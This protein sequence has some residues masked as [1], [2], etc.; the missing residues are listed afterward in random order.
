MRKSLILLLALLGSLSAANGQHYSCPPRFQLNTDRMQCVALICSS[1]LNRYGHPVSCHCPAFFQ[2]SGQIGVCL[3]LVAHMSHQSATAFRCSRSINGHG[4]PRTC[5]C[6]SGSIYSSS[7]G[8]CND[9]QTNAMITDNDIPPSG[10]AI[11]APTPSHIQSP[12]SSIV[13]E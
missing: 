10:S 3:D 6:P 1:A 2:Y 7:Q 8:V 9:V 12:E 4:H 5:H 11:I 13:T